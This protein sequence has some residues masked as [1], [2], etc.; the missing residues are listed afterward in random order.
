MKNNTRKIPKSNFEL[1]LYGINGGV[2]VRCRPYV[3]QGKRLYLYYGRLA[4]I[5]GIHEHIGTW[6]GGEGWT[7]D[8]PVMR[9]LKD[10]PSFVNQ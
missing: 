1:E 2:P 9:L 7:F 3:E 5:H 10:N 8:K 4:D 6:Q